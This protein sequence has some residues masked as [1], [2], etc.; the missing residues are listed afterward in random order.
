MFRKL[1]QFVTDV[2][3]EMAKVTWPGREELIGSTGVVIAL[4]IL[5]SAYLFSIDTVLQYIVK[6]FLVSA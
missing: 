5:L 3:I 2:K 4:W 1:S 6:Q